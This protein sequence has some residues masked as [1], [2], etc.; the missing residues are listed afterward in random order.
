[1]Q[2]LKDCCQFMLP[3]NKSPLITTCIVQIDLIYHSYS[4][5]RNH[6]ALVKFTR[7]TNLCSLWINL[8][9]NINYV[10]PCKLLRWRYILRYPKDAVGPRTSRWIM[11]RRSSMVTF[12]C[13]SKLYSSSLLL[14]VLLLICISWYLD[15]NGTILLQR[16]PR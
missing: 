1:M 15:S 7:S 10:I 6:L 4:C 5:A 11:V 9:G 2:L 8:L 13:F 16:N 14:R 12:W 3:L